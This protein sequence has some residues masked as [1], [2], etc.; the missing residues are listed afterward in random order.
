MS[1]QTL[2][3][4]RGSL[5]KEMQDLL[6]KA[7][8]ESRAL[9][10]EEEQQFDKLE[11]DESA[12]KK[13][14]EKE[15]RAVKLAAEMAESRGRQSEDRPA[16]ERGTVDQQELER[17]A[18]ESYLR[19]GEQGMNPE[20]RAALASRRATI[21]P[22]EK[23][24][25]TVTTSGG[26]YTIPQGFSGKLEEALK[27]FG[28]M[29]KVATVMPT[30]T[31]AQ[32]PYPTVND[33]SNTGALLDINTQVSAQ[34]LTFGVVTFD[35]YKYSSKLVLVPVELLQDSAFDLMNW[36]PG[37]L[38][39]RLGRITN[40]HFTT[41]DGSAKPNGIVTAATL[42]KTGATGQTT[43]ITYDDLVDMEHAVDA[44]YRQTGCSWMFHDTTLKAIKKL[45]DSQ[46]RPLWQPN[47]QAGQADSILGYPFTVNNDVAVMAASAKS[48]LFGV[49]SKYLIRDVKAVTV[50]R[51]QERYAD[52]HQVGF[53]AFSRHD[54]DLLDAGTHPVV[55]YANSAT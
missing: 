32:L 12:L 15:E 46:N 33:T 30:D 47:V 31:G 18:F 22:E 24:A 35:A 13:T 52:F 1:L 36:L 53:L 28:G 37:K 20:E 29:R 38:G 40:T 25:L 43:S 41:G 4:K 16:E 23:R 26:G 27:F 45:K 3:E 55:Y 50:L 7:T 10:G 51:L 39:E 49:L 5:V 2:R 17:R 19:Y 44:A 8:E 14:I 6:K 11:A 21:G 9:T 34:D 48:V 42:G 54:G